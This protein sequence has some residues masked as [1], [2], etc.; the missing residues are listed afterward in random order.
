M[1]PVREARA[2]PCLKGVRADNGKEF[3]ISTRSGFN[4]VSRVIHGWY[5]GMS[6]FLMSGLFVEYINC[7]DEKGPALVC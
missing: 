6:T 2:T 4:Y 3:E 5:N 1:T 7:V